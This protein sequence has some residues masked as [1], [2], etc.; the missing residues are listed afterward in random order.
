MLGDSCVSAAVRSGHRSSRQCALHRA[1]GSTRTPRAS[2]RS[3]RRAHLQ[4]R[5]GALR[6]AHDRS[7]RRSAPSSAGS[8][9]RPPATADTDVRTIEIPVSYG[10]AS[11]PDLAA[12][13]EFAK[14][15]EADVV[16]LH[17]ETLY[18]VYM[19]GFL[20]GFAY[21]GSVDRRIAMPRLETPRMRVAAGSVGIAAE[22]TG[23]Y[24]CDTPGG[25]RII[26]RTSI[27]GV[28]CDT[29]RAVSLE[30]RRSREVRRR[31]MLWLQCPF[32]VRA[33]SP[34]CRT[35]VDGAFSRAACL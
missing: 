26:G 17:T 1:R 12:V 4:R 21:M 23:I 9:R 10:G 2:R 19:L 16:R 5:D 11:G 28:R 30:G 32:C 31:V 6:P 25:W 35:W 14:C 33:C 15:S 29:A 20:P 22:Q 13:A 27:E 34:P 8:P 18:R 24:P 7:R 3:R